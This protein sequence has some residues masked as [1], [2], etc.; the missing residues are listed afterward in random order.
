M[1]IQ[2]NIKAEKK[3]YISK[4]ARRLIRIQKNRIDRFLNETKG[5]ISGTKPSQNICLW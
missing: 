3:A 4:E 1:P 5:N 2:R